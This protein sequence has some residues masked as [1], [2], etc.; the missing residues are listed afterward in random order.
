[1][2]TEPLDHAHVCPADCGGA[3]F[4]CSLM[5]C[6]GERSK[7]CWPCRQRGHEDLPPVLA[8]IAHATLA[9]TA[10]VKEPA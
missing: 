2:T 9:P 4:P 10:G 6:R 8:A 5:H 1:M 3:P 7:T